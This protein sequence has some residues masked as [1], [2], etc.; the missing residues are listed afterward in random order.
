MK[1]R[2]KKKWTKYLIE[3]LIVIIGISIA[4][5]VEDLAIKEKEENEKIAYLTSIKNDLKTDSLRLINNIKNNTIKIEKLMKSLDLIRNVSTIDE[6][7]T[8]VLEIGKYDFFDPDNF[9]LT[10]LLQS[11][12]FKLID[13]EIIKI[14]LLRL[15]KVYQHIDN[16]QKNFLQ[17]LDD[18][19][20]PMLLTKLDYIEFEAVDPEFFYGIEIRN[21]CAY[22]INETN[23]HIGN[24]QVA[25]KQVGKVAELIEG[26]LSY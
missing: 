3:L 23:Q 6:V 10:S 12:D 7:L 5:A 25:L 17:A 19:Y 15:L 16:M 14:E 24:Y 26:E 22:T 4:F 1:K 9:T 8:S 13:S 20:F 21:Y 18:N 2:T 11:G